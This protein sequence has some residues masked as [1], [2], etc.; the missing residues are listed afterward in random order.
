MPRISSGECVPI[1][2]TDSTIQPVDRKSLHAI[3]FSQ[4]T[5]RSTILGPTTTAY[6]A[7]IVV[8]KVRLME[9]TAILG[10]IFLKDWPL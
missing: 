6:L 4:H 5:F 10:R 3:L 7:R 9:G 8:T 2:G 1:H